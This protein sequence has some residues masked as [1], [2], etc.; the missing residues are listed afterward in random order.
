M[1]HDGFLTQYH[2]EWLKRFEESSDP[3]GERNFHSA[4]LARFDD[5]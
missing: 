1:K 4:T 3:K 5:S 2:Q